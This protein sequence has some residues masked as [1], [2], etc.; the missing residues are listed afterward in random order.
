MTRS[1][2]NEGAYSQGQNVGRG[3]IIA[4]TPSLLREV[5]PF[6]G[7]VVL[8]V[9]AGG[10]A[11]QVFDELPGDFFIGR[12]GILDTLVYVSA[13]GQYRLTAP[14]GTELWFWDF[15][16]ARPAQQQGQFAKLEDPKGN[17]TEVTSLLADG[18]HRRVQETAGGTTNDLYYSDAWQVL[19]ERVASGGTSVPRVQYVWSPVYIDALV[20]RDRD[21]NADGTLDERLY[22]AQDANFNVTALV[23]GS[24]AVVERYAYDP[25]GAATVLEDDYD[26]KGGGSGYGWSQGFQGMFFDPVSGTYGSRGRFGYSPTLGRWVQTDPI[27]FEG[28]INF[29]AFVGNN[30]ANRLDPSGLIDITI[31]LQSKNDTDEEERSHMPKDTV[32]TGSG[33]SL[34]KLLE[35][36]KQKAGGQKIGKLT[37]TAHCGNE[38]MVYIGPNDIMN[39][40]DYATWKKLLAEGK[41]NDAR[42]KSIDKQVQFLRALASMAED[43]GMTIDF[44]Q[45]NSGGGEKGKQLIGEIHDICGGKTKIVMY[46][47]YVGWYHGNPRVG[48]WFTAWLG[49]KPGQVKKPAGPVQSV[50]P[51]P[52]VVHPG[53][54]V[55]NVTGNWSRDLDRSLPG[56]ALKGG[57]KW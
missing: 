12:G 30:P 46:D 51:G 20:L 6:S 4:E 56:S 31:D 42:F 54:N 39:A 44:V 27:M 13:S 48:S 28:G 34:D 14:D 19:E 16:P 38:G 18:L 15:D 47:G 9:V 1:W 11:Q 2:T 23:D 53:T 22:V 40:G 7:A 32:W 49:A 10:T 33:M 29:Y 52:G 57:P 25:F 43:G 24:G 8:T 35:L 36:I 17:V 3:W 5:D 41:T 50:T 26:V 45:C 55:P 37:L 21:T